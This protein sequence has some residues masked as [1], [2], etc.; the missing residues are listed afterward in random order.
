[1]RGQ[2]LSLREALRRAAYREARTRFEEGD[3]LPLLQAN[4]EL[5]EAWLLYSEDKRTTGGWYVLRDGEV[6]R[7][8]DLDSRLR[9][10]TIEP[11]I[12]GYVVR[13]LDHWARLGGE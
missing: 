3:L 8:G 2:E 1:M 11:A 13:E 9:F 5:V 12:A 6:G 10:S 4:P 7:V